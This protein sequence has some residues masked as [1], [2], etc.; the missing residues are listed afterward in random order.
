MIA[1]ELISWPLPRQS[2]KLGAAEKRDSASLCHECGSAYFD[3]PLT[4]SVQP[5]NRA[6]FDSNDYDKYTNDRNNFNQKR[7]SDFEGQKKPRLKIF[8]SY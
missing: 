4:S 8:Y 1:V 5:R 2:A 7:K 6:S 3:A